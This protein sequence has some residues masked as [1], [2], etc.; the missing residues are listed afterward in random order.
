MQAAMS[1][2]FRIIGCLSPD[3]FYAI[4]FALVSITLFTLTSG[5]LIQYQSGQVWLR[6]IYYINV[7]F[8]SVMSGPQY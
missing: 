3:V 4:K 8:S 1:L 2:W 6:W 5:Y 7:R